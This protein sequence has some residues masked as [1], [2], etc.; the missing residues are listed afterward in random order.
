MPHLAVIM[1]SI[2]S[3]ISTYSGMQSLMTNVGDKGLGIFGFMPAEIINLISFLFTLTVQIMIVYHAMHIKGVG[4]SIFSLHRNLVLKVWHITVY[5]T[6]LSLSVGFS[7]AFWFERIGADTYS[8]DI[9]REEVYKSLQRLDEF[10]NAYTNFSNITSNLASYSQQKAREE[11]QVGGTCGG[12][13]KVG[14]G[15]RMRLRNE[16][17]IYFA[18]QK[19]YFD[20]Q[21]R[22]IEQ[23]IN[24]L[25][26]DLQFNMTKVK[27]NFTSEQIEK[28]Q[29]QL[30]QANLKA[31]ILRQSSI[32]TAFISWLDQRIETGKS[33]M[34]D[35]NGKLFT[36][37]DRT[38]ETMRNELLKV[39]FPP[40]S[41]N[42]KLFNPND[43]KQS[44]FL[45]FK[46]IGEFIS[47]IFEKLWNSANDINI[48][49]KLAEIIPL[50][51]G[52]LIDFMIFIV[53]PPQGA[54]HIL[55][56][57]KSFLSSINHSFTDKPLL[58][59][60][61]WREL[62]KNIALIKKYEFRY[63]KRYYLIY[64][65]HSRQEEH[66]M[67]GEMI[68]LLVDNE[69]IKLL[70]GKIKS[71]EIERQWIN[72]HPDLI[73][74]EVFSIYEIRP[75]IRQELIIEKWLWSKK[76]IDTT[77]T[78]I[79]IL[80]ALYRAV[81]NNIYDYLLSKVKNRQEKAMARLDV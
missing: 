69:G 61:V 7:Y 49:L 52:I 3:F 22:E 8:K 19:R 26:Y 48:K 44:V 50:V 60:Y 77:P 1:L 34:P 12:A 30:N 79:E 71:K 64:P 15:P 53:A 31:N 32:R 6:F 13:A 35:G 9:Y 67:L 51:G 68:D 14:A 10:R 2:I 57:R 65:T 17:A 74:L 21:T 16:D 28:M 39:E 18:A 4:W 27:G 20:Q 62:K 45:A 23:L 36:C 58:N 78:T 41:E 63:G 29:L 81:L 24:K 40:L 55:N 38:I 25:N 80:Q 43:S 42:V 46:R 54:N 72:N 70:S 76:K 11:R 75:K 73:E 66:L 5:I 56:R 47:S 33:G 37:P 59:E